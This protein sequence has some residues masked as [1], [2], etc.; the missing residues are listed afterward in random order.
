[1]ANRSVE[2]NRLTRCNAPA[3]DQIS[4]NSAFGVSK[5]F[6]INGH[7]YLVGPLIL[8]HKGFNSIIILDD[9]FNLTI[10]G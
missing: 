4:L 9:N 10:V 1:M 6:E 3:F 8:E 2:L 5:R 7:L